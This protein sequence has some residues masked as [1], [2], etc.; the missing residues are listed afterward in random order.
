MVL[1]MSNQD[2]R[3]P[4]KPLEKTREIDNEARI[5]KETEM[6]RKLNRNQKWI[7]PVRH[8]AKLFNILE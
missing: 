3:R 5:S 7:T 6:K 4:E 8:P 2:F 1:E